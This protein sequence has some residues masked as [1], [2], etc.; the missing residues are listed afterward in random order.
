[1]DFITIEDPKSISKMTNIGEIVTQ[2]CSTC[3]TNTSMRYDGR[4]MHEEDIAKNPRFEKYRDLGNYT[5][6]NCR[7]TL[8]IK[9]Q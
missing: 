6:Q 4:A 2:Y 1:M 3:R 8:S 5:C 9:D 7:G